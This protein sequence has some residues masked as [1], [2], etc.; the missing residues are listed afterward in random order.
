MNL[1]EVSIKKPVFAWMLMAA[2][3]VFGGISFKRMGVSA[4]PDVDSPI[5]SVNITLEGAAPEVMEV[6][7]VDPI[8]DAFMGIQGIKQLSS[9]SRTGSANV[10]VE[11]ELDKNIDTAVQEIQTKLAQ[12]QR[13]LPKEVDPPTVSKSN[14]E[15]QPI[16]WLAVTT[17]R[18]K[19]QELMT[20]VRD[21]VKDKFST[22]EGVAEVFMSGYVDPSLRVWIDAE[23]L[24]RY[25]FAV[26]D[27]MNTIQQEHSELPAGRIEMPDKELNI[28]TMG[29]A[30]TAEQFGK[31]VINRRG[32]APNFSPISLDQVAKIEDGLADV[33]R[34]SRSMGKPAVGLGIRKQRGANSVQV[35]HQAKERMQEV[36]SQLPEGVE[37]GVRFDSTQFIEESIGE[38]NFTLLLSALLTAL[39]CWLFLGSWSATMNVV[40]AIPTSVVG[41]FIVLYFLGFTLNTFTLLGLSLAIGIVVDDAI[42]VLENIVRHKEQGKSRMDAALIG[43]REITFAALAATAAIIAIF[44]PVAF[45][46]GVIGRFFFQFG[47]TLS[48]AVALSLLEALTLTPMRCSQFL[49]TGK[50]TTRL[51]KWVERAFHYSAQV[52]GRMIP[53]ILNHRWKVIGVAVAFCLAT[54]S[55]VKVLKKEFVPAQDEGRLMIRSQAPVGSSIEYTDLKYAEIEKYMN[56]RPEV[57]RSFGS[58]GGFGG[59]VNTAMMFVSL[60]PKKDRP[61]NPKTGE[62]YTQQE[63]AEVYRDDLKK[64]PNFRSRVQDPSL[65]GFS[66]GRGFP[67]EFTIRGPDWDTLIQSSEQMMD[68]MEKSGLMTDVDSNYQTGM[69]EIRVIPDRAKA[70]MRGVSIFDIGTTINAMMGGVTAGKYSKGGHRYDVRVRL[71][72]SDRTKPEDIRMLRVRNNRGELIPMSEVI[73]LEEKP[74]LQAISRQ[75]RERAINIYANVAPGKSQAQAIDTVKKLSREVLPKGY[76]AVIGGSAQTFQESFESLIFALIL[77]LVVSYMVLASQFNSFIH[78]LTV[79]VALPFSVSGAFVALLLGGQTLNIYSMI[80][81]VLLMGI[82]KK[83]SI[84]LVDFTNQVRSEGKKVREALITACPMRLRPILMTSIATVVG[85]I[86][87]A[88]A[89]GP[90]AE[91]RIP[92]A[93]AVIGGVAVSTALTLFVVPCVYSL[94]AR[95]R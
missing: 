52:Y 38:L 32:G 16:L 9:S 59:D 61:K 74:S 55:L 31:I 56:G 63:L 91:S 36:A 39:V 13:R 79:L 25:E 19:E 20:L 88:L 76:R 50:R 17:D 12:V 86:P 94:F 62:P 35:A 24:N 68:T 49:D 29:E 67:V 89:I 53:L 23:K 41:S 11:F 72:A 15:D 51:G 8:E 7:V 90:G 4:L 10:N 65:S 71:Q 66:G 80:G 73:R 46:K 26:T 57:E 18:L 37:I 5:V 83:N 22:I 14:P 6:D 30:P 75:D 84:L 95:E 42:M 81:L 34:R 27:V 2:L 82:V 48:V 44:L 92:M 47:V 40:L 64:I 45:M 21:Q 78:P 70:K 3:I 87:P 58:I 93:L 85:A 1:S 77:G 33:R 43:A 69:P 60:K 54:F 28:R